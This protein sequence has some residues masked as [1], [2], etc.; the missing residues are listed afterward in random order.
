MSYHSSDSNITVVTSGYLEMIRADKTT[1][2]LIRQI[3]QFEEK[4][5]LVRAIDSH[6]TQELSHRINLQT[7]TLGWRWG[8]EVDP[9]RWWMSSAGWQIE[10]NAQDQYDFDL[11][12]GI[13]PNSYICND[14]FPDSP[15]FL[16]HMVGVEP[17]ALV[18]RMHLYRVKTKVVIQMLADRTD[19]VSS[20]VNAGWEHEV[21]DG[22]L[23]LHVPFCRNAIADAFRTGNFE[24]ALTPF[25]D[26]IGKVAAMKPIFDQFHTLAKAILADRE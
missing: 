12:F 18:I 10:A 4:R 15:S 21:E 6:L 22:W 5:T 16:A 19:L 24:E 7:Q 14:E 11:H 1:G 13:T 25:N 2:D 20:L 9:L 8:F 26:A 17:Y 3:E 23:D